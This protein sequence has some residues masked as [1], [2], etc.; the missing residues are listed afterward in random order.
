M[1]IRNGFVSNSSSSSF[2]IMKYYLSQ[3]QIDKILNYQE[4]VEMYLE[5]YSIP[6]G[7]EDGD[8]DPYE[9]DI[10]K[11]DFACYEDSW[12]VKEYE[13]FIFAETSMDNFDFCEFFRYIGVDEQDILVCWDD[14]YNTDPTI[15]QER[16]LE[17]ERKKLIKEIRK[18]KLNQIDGKENL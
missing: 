16:Y 10:R 11:Y 15:Y 8:D 6:S 7:V 5:E 2:V 13:D 14:G 3:E 1:K 17:E 4:E 12:N 18:E 9:E